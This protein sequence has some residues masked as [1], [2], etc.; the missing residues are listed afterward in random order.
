MSTIVAK[1]Q[2]YVSAGN[3][4]L[5]R[6][7]MSAYSSACDFVS[8]I[9]YETNE[10]K[11]KSL[12]KMLYPKIRADFGLGSQ[13]ACSTLITTI[14]RYKSAK[15]NGHEG[16]LI[17]FKSP[18]CDLVWNRDYSLNQNVFSVNTLKGRIKLQFQ[19]KGMKKYFDGTWQ[20]GTAK[21]INKFN[22]WFL[23]VP[24]T[25]DLDLLQESNV[26]NVVGV[27]LGINFLATSYESNG[28]TTFYSGKEVK[29]T[30]GQLKALRK[31]LQKKQT[32]SARKRLKEI[33][34][35]ENRYMTDVN[36]CITKALVIKYPK[37]TLFVLEDLTGVYAMQL[38]KSELKIVMCLYHGRFINLGK[39]LNIKQSYMD[40]K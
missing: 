16:R 5:L 38:K 30:R 25:K 40:I 2:I 39:C 36:H 28:K 13:M 31:E 22:K 19:T 1:I 33:G 17:K 35:R 23:H 29:N 26:N 14:A 27:D 20:F 18:E 21:L 34:Q 24:M 7:T 37:G 6:Q 4:S 12:H 3:E 15:S 11:Q 10:L 8:S 9:I 32:S